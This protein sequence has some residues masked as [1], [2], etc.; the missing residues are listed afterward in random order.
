MLS[1]KASQAPV[2]IFLALLLAS[3]VLPSAAHG[4]EAAPAMPDDPRAPRYHEVER[5]FFTGFEV[6]YLSLFKTPVA[7][8]AKFPFAPK[9]GGGNASGLLVGTTLGYDLSSRLAVA[10]YAVGGNAR[11]SIS[12][13]AFSVLSAGGDVRLALLG[14][15]DSYG[16][17]RL[18][19][20]LH[21]R[22]GLL[23]TQ[24]EG[25]LG[26]SDVYVA[27][28]PGVEYFTHLRHFSVGLA[29]DV[30]YLT[31]AKAAG[32]TVTPTVRYTF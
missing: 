8:P 29:A 18:Y 9:G 16:V 1:S 6:G 15:P 28:G 14:W 32:L 26:K 5:G 17:E 10:L 22:A 30:A 7:D 11:A 31:K 19:F 4:Q 21:G 2:R 12:Y 20:Y 27:G 13:G 25:L 24:P 3:A 23:I